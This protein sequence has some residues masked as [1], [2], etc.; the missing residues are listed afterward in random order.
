MVE[1]KG[2]KITNFFLYV[3]LTALAVICFLP[4]Y[5]MIMNATRDSGAIASSLSLIPGDQFF[6][7]YIRMRDAGTNIWRGFKNSLIIAVSG[8]ALSAYFGSL[9]AYGFSIY[10]FKGRKT[11]FWVLM[12]S[13][14]VPTQLGLI[15]F[16]KVISVLHLVDSRL[17]L[18]IPVI[19]NANFVFFVKLYMDSV[20]SP[21][22]IESARIDG[23]KELG[24]FN[25]IVIPMII[26]SIATMSIFTFIGLWNNYIAP[27]IVLYDEKKYTIPV[28]TAIARGVYQN[29][30]GAVYVVIALSMVPIMVVFAFC[31]KYI[32]GGLTAGSVKE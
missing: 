24:I 32:I 5:L 25:K 22:I 13:M 7:N 21:S 29:D 15:G 12:G 20:I 11:L 2:T 9:T 10:R 3:F 26:P 14:M 17:A 31:S 6:E 1:S 23:A 19:A 27:L 30:F 4:F 18:I 16:F 8:T 28:I